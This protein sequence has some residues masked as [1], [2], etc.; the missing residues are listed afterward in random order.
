MP[1]RDSR[2]DRGRAR[3]RLL[4]RKLGAEIG[5]TR[6]NAGLSLRAAGR[7][8]GLS[9]TQFGRIERAELPNVS[10]VQLALACAAVGLELGA[11]AYPSGDP[12]RDRAQLRV[13]E[14]L[15]RWL[16]A[17]CTLS[18]EVPLPIPGDLRALDALT[19]LDG[20][21]IAFEVETRLG[22]LQA[23]TRK[24]LL[25]QRDSGVEVLIL[26]AADTNHNRLILER[27]RETLH[28]T[29]PLERRAIA[30]ALRGGR[31]PRANG[32]LTI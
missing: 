14:R 17:T 3:A 12:V 8:V 4:I 26:V 10:A 18:T 1:I 2:A 29:F 15:R 6:R 22:D 32:I 25:K 13:I 24:L 7:A 21:R 16:P 9:H 31:L 11:G 23:L 20:G 27:E 19:T 28:E 30:T 5:T